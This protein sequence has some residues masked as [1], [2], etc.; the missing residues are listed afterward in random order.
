MI[1]PAVT[2]FRPGRGR[3]GG[4][5]LLDLQLG[6]VECLV[7]I[8]DEL[9]RL[10]VQ[11]DGL[12]QRC[13]FILHL[14]QQILQAPQALLKCLW[15]FHVSGLSARST[16]STVHCADARLPLTRIFCPGS[17]SATE[18]QLPARF[19]TMA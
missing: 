10:R 1:N 4:V 12:V 14:G 2:G 13:L 18:Q 9:G 7:A 6:A 5:Y 15:F 19:S 8:L 17:S 3:Q 16:A 11:L